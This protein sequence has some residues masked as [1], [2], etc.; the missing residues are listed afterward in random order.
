MHVL[1]HTQTQQIAQRP[2]GNEKSVGSASVVAFKAEKIFF[3]AL[4]GPLPDSV[5]AS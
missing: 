5:H 4:R 2:I 3:Q 1:N